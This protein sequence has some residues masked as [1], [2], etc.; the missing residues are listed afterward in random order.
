MW[1]GWWNPSCPPTRSNRHLTHVRKMRQKQQWP[2][3]DQSPRSRL[4]VELGDAWMVQ[5]V[6]RPTSAQVM[7]SSPFVGSSPTAGSVLT[8]SEAGACFGFYVSLSLCPSPDRSLSQKQNK[9]LKRYKKNYVFLSI[10][11]PSISEE[12]LSFYLIL[13]LTDK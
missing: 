9:T 12:D 4:G 1:G 10:H 5:S 11:P 2:A 6:K 3:Q 7:M 8:S 13:Y